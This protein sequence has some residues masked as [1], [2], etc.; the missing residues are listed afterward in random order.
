[1]TANQLTTL[2]GL[3]QRSDI[4]TGTWILVCDGFSLELQGIIPHELEG[5][6]VCARGILESNYSVFAISDKVMNI[7]S[8]ERA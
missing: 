2:T 1:M 8:I 5:C 7:K 4:G 6:N 3:L